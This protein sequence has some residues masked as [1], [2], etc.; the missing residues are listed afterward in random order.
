MEYQWYHLIPV[1]FMFINFTKTK[2]DVLHEIVPKYEA[3]NYHYM[4][5]SLIPLVLLRNASLKNIEHAIVIFSMSAGLKAFTKQL[6]YSK[7]QHDYFF[8]FAVC[9]VLIAINYT[10]VPRTSF[11]V[12]ALYLYMV[13]YSIYQLSLRKDTTANLFQ[14]FIN[15]HF[16]FFFSK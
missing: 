6:T 3:K 1:M 13:T 11:Y 16:I 4:L 14:D 15:T 12:Y 9:C 8:I 10:L 7:Q 5:I 2:T